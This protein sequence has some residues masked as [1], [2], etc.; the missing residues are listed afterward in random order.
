MT[1]EQHRR[2]M[3]TLAKV[4]RAV[5]YWSV[6]LPFTEEEKRLIYGTIQKPGSASY[7]D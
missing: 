7:L 5:W 3:D 4:D 2:Y 6:M 1:N